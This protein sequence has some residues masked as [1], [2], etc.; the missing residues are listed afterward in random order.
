[1]PK[2]AS[3]VIIGAGASGLTAALELKRAG[4]NVTIIEARD[5]I[6]GRMFTKKDPRSGA[7]VE[8]G[9]EFIH[10]RPPQIWNLLRKNKI[11]ARAVD[12]DNFCIQNGE[13]S[14]CDFFSQIDR[15][16]DK[17]TDRRRDQTFLQFLRNYEKKNPIPPEV[18][19]RTLRYIE[20]FHAADPRLISIHSLVKG[21]QADENIDGER[22]YRI[23]KGYQELL[24]VFQSRIED[25]T[26][27]L[28]TQV[29]QISWNQG[30]VKI[31]ARAKS[32]RKIYQASQVLITVSLAVL[33][34]KSIKFAPSL[35]VQ[36]R[37]ALSKL[38]MGKVIR[39]TLCFRE[40][41]WE[42][43]RVNKKSLSKLSFLFSDDKLF[44]TWWTQ[45]PSET[46][47]IV[48]WAPF[49]AAH[50]LSG[51]SLDAITNKATRTLSTLLHIGHRDLQ[52]L[53]SASYFYDWEDDPFS[54]GAYSYVKVGG[55]HAQQDLAKPIA[56]RLF[57][58]GEASDITGYNGT[59]HGAMASGQRAA[60]EIIRAISGP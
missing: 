36:K 45:M 18:R 16:L 2:E 32:K 14:G 12:G 1:M 51:D 42:N 29:E 59:V 39:V 38:A 19:A 52:N 3:I 8:L 41:F 49:H 37:L 31:T 5:R 13:L 60:E 33:Q 25:V 11:S 26:I 46:P 48:G 35:P 58:A 4:V 22:A 56:N 24:N 28:N 10:G 54:R 9:A 21:M 50:Q 17:L 53:L 57:F 7:V 6:G 15:V 20:G 40:R 30:E 27:D 55:G 23:R 34:S 47:V 43:L 44:P